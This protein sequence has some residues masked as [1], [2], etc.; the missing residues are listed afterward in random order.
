M[1]RK[2]VQVASAGDNSQLTGVVMKVLDRDGIDFVEYQIDL[3][4]CMSD[5]TKF[6]EDLQK[7]FTIIMGQCSPSMEQALDS[8]TSFKA[9]KEN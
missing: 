1:I 3:K 8:E 7:C 5:K 6:N 2:V 4:Q 9:M